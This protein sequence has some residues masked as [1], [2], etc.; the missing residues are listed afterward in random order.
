M[1]NLLFK[2]YLIFIS[3]LALLLLPSCEDWD[4][5]RTELMQALCES[6]N[7]NNGNCNVETGK[8]DCNEN[9]TGEFCDTPIDSNNPCLGID[10]GP[11]GSCVNGVCECNGTWTGTYC[12]SLTTFLKVHGIEN[13]DELGYAAI[14]LPN[15]NFAMIGEQDGKAYFLKVNFKGELLLQK[16][17]ESL[18][19]FEPFSPIDR[20]GYDNTPGNVDPFGRYDIILDNNALKILGYQYSNGKENIV[21][22]SADQDGN[23]INSDVKIIE[24]EGN[25]RPM[26]FCQTNTGGFAIA[27]Y[28]QNNYNNDFLLMETNSVG[29]V[30]WSK[31]Y[32][33]SY[34]DILWSVKE[35]D[36]G[37]LAVCGE[38]GKSTGGSFYFALIDK[39]TQSII[40]EAI[41]ENGADARAFSMDLSSNNEFILFGYSG[42]FAN[43]QYQW[44]KYEIGEGF[45]LN[46]T[47]GSNSSQRDIGSS[48]VIGSNGDIVGCGFSGIGNLFDINLVIEPFDAAPIKKEFAF[49]KEAYNSAWQVIECSDGGYLI[50]GTTASLKQ[51]E[52]YN[53]KQ[54]SNI[55]L[56]KTD[57]Q[58]N[59]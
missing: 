34:S 18:S 17:F 25:Q 20:N 47:T 31:T 40:R 56:I 37:T 11:N 19:G 22:V 44:E 28:T 53:N 32:G 12:D 50:V 5:E 39:P 35:L 23:F 13:K 49:E 4:L 41:S 27:G 30:I 14:E 42:S 21:L 9:W 29:E 15:G 26:S 48:M 16:E 51:G 57:S 58:G 59:Y 24:M 8:C 7:C 46:S 3:I 2:S 36:F 10:C 52:L 38:K 1:P 55:I 54:D 45:T 43:E 33:D 6:V